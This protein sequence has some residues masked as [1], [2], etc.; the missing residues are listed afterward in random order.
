MRNYL[1]VDGYNVINGWSDLKEIAKE[2]LEEARE[3]L[4]EI[5][6]NYRSFTGET[7]VVVFDAHL[8]KSTNLKH[9]QTK[10]VDVVFT[11]EHQTADSYIEKR[12][13]EL[14]KDRRNRVRVATSDWAEQQVVLGSGATRISVRELK[15]EVEKIGNDITKK[16]ETMKKN[17]STLEERIDGSVAEIL[18]KWR[19]NK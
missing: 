3:K 4:I 9:I 8:V 10:G 16:T 5:L 2:S 7:V 18:E 11:K 19:R 15:I 12:V 17:R 1:L 14:T 13:E 6:V